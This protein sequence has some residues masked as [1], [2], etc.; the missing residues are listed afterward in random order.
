[1]STLKS[2]KEDYGC[3]EKY[4]GAA[5]RSIDVHIV[6]LGCKKRGGLSIGETDREL[7]SLLLHASRGR[8]SLPH[9]SLALEVMLELRAS[10]DN[11][12]TN[13][14]KK[15]Q[16]ER[17]SPSISGKNELMYMVDVFVFSADMYFAYQSDVGDIWSENRIALYAVIVHYID[18]DWIM[19]VKEF[20]TS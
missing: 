13:E 9:H 16:V 15:L 12:T 1:M 20:V 19:H 14:M 17:I 8:Y 18:Q 10:V 3:V 5:K 2:L 11:V 6:K 7:E 4:T